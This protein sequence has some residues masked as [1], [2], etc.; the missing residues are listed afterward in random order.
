MLT[1]TAVA[2]FGSVWLASVFDATPS[3]NGQVVWAFALLVVTTIV[4][5]VGLNP[6][7]YVVN[8]GIIAECIA[9]VGIGLLLLLFFRNHP[10]SYLWEGLGAAR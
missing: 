8:V 2:Y 9:S 4:N 6:L 3:A 5:A 7:K 1:V 10:I